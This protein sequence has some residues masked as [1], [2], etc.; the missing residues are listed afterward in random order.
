[1]AKEK[2]LIAQCGQETPVSPD[3]RVAAWRSAKLFDIK[4]KCYITTG[5]VMCQVSEFTGRYA[6]VHRQAGK[7]ELHRYM[8]KDVDFFTEM[9][10]ILY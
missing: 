4:V 3:L 7:Q 1:M 6:P 8:E 2:E 9:R 5:W 10:Y